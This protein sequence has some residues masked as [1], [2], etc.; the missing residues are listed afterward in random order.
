[1]R[2]CTADSD[3]GRRVGI[4]K[5]IRF[6]RL[7]MFH[8]PPRRFFEHGKKIASLTSA[9]WKARFAAGGGHAARKPAQR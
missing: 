7:S 9:P 4:S 1:M 2:S 8:D 6:A 3:Y 5:V